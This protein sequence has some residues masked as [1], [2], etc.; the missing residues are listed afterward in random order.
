MIQINNNI[1]I[2]NSQN[3]LTLFGFEDY[4][5][6]FVQAHAKKK[7]PNAIILKGQKGI[8]KATFVNHFINYIL[9]INEENN[10][11][12]DKHSINTK[13]KSY[14]L[15]NNNIH[16]NFFNLSSSSEKNIKIDEVRQLI[17]FLKKT[18]YSKNLKIIFIDDA[19]NLNNFAA[20]ALLKS[21]EE[22][23]P[24]TF[25]FLI[26]D[27]SYQIL[28]T[29][30]SRCVEYNL[31]FDIKKKQEIFV[32][33]LKQHNVTPD[34][35]KV[36]DLFYFDSPGNILKYLSIFENSH[37]DISK[38]HLDSIMYLIEIYK[39]NNDPNYIIIISLF[40]ELFYRNLSLNREKNINLIIYNKIKIINLL[41]DM[42]K[43]NLDKKN[44]F[45]IISDILKNDSK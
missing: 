22:P 17:K 28:D 2:E 14:N 3:Q 35:N 41:N 44:L 25:F 40:I 26:H 16:P 38:D 11:I 36:N 33:L 19:Q 20:N 24:N 32:Q 8:G 4:F 13:N 27:N 43:Y 5:S 7:L 39:N 1:K 29:I 12:I 30:K 23:D 15:I 42:T 31:F 6:F 37:L 10:Y 21:L 45:L 9:S 34:I 18:T